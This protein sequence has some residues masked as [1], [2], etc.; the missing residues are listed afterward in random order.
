MVLF[1]FFL[2]L[3]AFACDNALL[4]PTKVN[5]IR[6]QRSIDTSN[7]PQK[8]KNVL[9]KIRG[10]FGA[11]GPNIER[12]NVDSLFNLFLGNGIINGVF[13]DNGNVTFARHLIQTE[14]LEY[15]KK[16]DSQFSKTLL[17]LIKNMGL[18]AAGI[19]PNPMGVANTAILQT[20][21]GIYAMFERDLPY[22]IAV[23]FDKCS[24]ATLGK[25]SVKNVPHLSGHARFH[26]SVIKSI[27]YNVKESRAFYREFD[28]PFSLRL[29]KTFDTKY[30][31]I[32]HDF[33]A[34]D[35]GTVVFAD[36]PFYFS[37]KLDQ[38][39]PVAF[40]TSKPTF[41]QVAKGGV[42]TILD[43]NQSFYIFHYGGDIAENR[44]HIEFYTSIYENVDF[45]KIDLYGKY[46]RFIL[47]VGR[48]ITTIER[49]SELDQY[50]LDFPVKCG[51]YTI[52]RN[53]DMAK[54]RING[55]VVCDGLDM[56][57]AFF[58]EN[59]SFC[60]EPAVI[61][62]ADGDNYLVGFAYGDIAN[63]SFCILIRVL[64]NGCLDREYIEIPIDVDIGIGFHSAFIY[65][66]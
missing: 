34:T 10:F 9:G 35:R 57:D 23:D 56:R 21:S 59:R 33:V 28:P 49:N 6:S 44:T 61:T 3:H 60:G 36:C 42:R 16:H 5:P 18:Y 12:S 4:R 41:F 20:P 13:F 27:D 66:T 45:S 62:D 46:R 32:I 40:D 30:M 24:I 31:P 43:T 58:L 52:L 1:Y 7:F 25:S 26:N 65:G 55:F 22:Q 37:G 19:L 50:N 39:I 2:F 11:I 29:S 38:N 51:N 48:G 63:E 54:K 53:L 15:E 17:H 8:S 47:D 14:K 64:K